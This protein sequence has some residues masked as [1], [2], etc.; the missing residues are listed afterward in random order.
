MGESKAPVTNRLASLDGMRAISIMLVITAHV[1]GA[2][3]V[4]WRL[5]C[6]N[7]GV[8]VFFIISGFLITALL[9]NEQAKTG[10]ISLPDFYMR[11]FLRIFPAYWV[12]VATIAILLYLGLVT[13]KWSEFLPTLAYYSNYRHPQGVLGHTWSLSVEE[14]FYLLWPALM[15]ALGVRK[16]YLGCVVMLLMAPV[17]RVASDLGYWPTE[18]RYAWES[19]CDALATGCALALL[20]EPL[21]ARAWYRKIVESRLALIAPVC[22]IVLLAALSPIVARDLVVRDVIGLPLLNLSLAIVLDRYMRFPQLPFGRVLNSAPL[23]WI[24][25]LS[26]SIYLWQQLFVFRKLPLFEELAAVL[27]CA[28]A[29]Y[30]LVERPFLGLRAKFRTKKPAVEPGRFESPNPV[31]LDSP[32]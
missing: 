3:P 27:A 11:R 17:F 21:W 19:V 25:T 5:D 10:R 7:L 18:S 6:G 23:V 29:S 20:R 12:F 1:V 32:G 8:R 22:A 15:V 13:A 14:Q 2:I 24:G 30:Y 4:F 31:R 16:A 26:Y 9:I 28:A